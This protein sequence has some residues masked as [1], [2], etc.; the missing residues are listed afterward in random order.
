MIKIL[1]PILI[2]T[3]VLV[4]GYFGYKQISQVSKEEPTPTNVVTPASSPIS[5]ELKTFQSKDMKFSVELPSEY[6]A[7]EKMGSVNITT[8]AGEIYIDRNGTNFNNLNDYLTDLRTKNKPLVIDEKKTSINNNQAILEVI[9]I[10]GNEFE[11]REY[12]IYND[13]WVYLLFTNT[14]SLYPALDQ[15]AQSFRYTP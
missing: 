8:K 13:N 12:M 6:Q 11:T 2:I 1:L 10:P 9:K 4:S 7:N 3:V 5:Q 14:Q 15:I